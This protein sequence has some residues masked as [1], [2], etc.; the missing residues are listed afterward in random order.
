M[1]NENA[2][3]NW[4]VME[5]KLFE[6]GIKLLEVVMQAA[7]ERAAQNGSQ[8]LTNLLHRTDLAP[9]LVVEVSGIDGNTLTMGVTLHSRATGEP[10]ARLFEIVAE[11]A[12]LPCLH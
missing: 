3:I 2:G 11:G 6:N 12:P 7:Q 8:L 4:D 10:V 5:S 1:N 9:R